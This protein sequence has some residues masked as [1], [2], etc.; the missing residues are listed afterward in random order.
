M[1]FLRTPALPV[2]ARQAITLVVSAIVHFVHPLF[3][4]SQRARRQ[5]THNLIEAL[6]RSIDF[7]WG[8]PLHAV[9][10]IPMSDELI[11]SVATAS[12]NLS[13][14]RIFVTVDR[15]GRKRRF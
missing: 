7:I 4:H 3:I 5:I 14:D 12:R 9:P 1:A 2:R 6:I 13:L 15:A 10:I 8:I 11:S